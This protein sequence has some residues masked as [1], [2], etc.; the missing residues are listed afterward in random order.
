M[1]PLRDDQPSRTRPLITLALIAFNIAVFVYQLGL[2]ERQ[3]ERLLEHAALLPA[4]LTDSL[5]YGPSPELLDTAATLV[6]SQF[7]HGGLLHLALNLW[8]L[9]IFGDN[10]EDRLGPFRY[11]WFYLVCGA[12]AGLAHVLAGPHSLVPTVGAS[13]AISGVMGAYI[14]FY[15]RARVVTLIPVLFYPL[16]FNLPAAVFVGLWFA[17]QVLSGL[18]EAGQQESGGVAWWAHIGGFLAGLGMVAVLGR[19]KRRAPRDY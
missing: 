15:P 11:L 19:R 8:A 4:R 3:T 10:V 6:T 13:G 9:W 5:A 17:L 18:A 16:F 2:D 1:F 14:V 7:L 12:V